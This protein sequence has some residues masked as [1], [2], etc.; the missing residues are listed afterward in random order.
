MVITSAE[1]GDGK[2]SGL[3]GTYGLS[4]KS[5]DG[6]TEVGSV[7]TG[8]SDSDL[9]YL[10]TELKK[11]IDIHDGESFHFLPRIVI[12]VDCDAITKDEKTGNL[13]L[14]FPRMVRIRDDKAP[15][16]CDTHTDMV[17]MMG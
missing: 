2:R 7:G 8:F 4:A 11:I 17:L 3:F 5:I 12:E 1:Y 15:A 10:T 14:R 13:A 9:A 16:E 6:Y